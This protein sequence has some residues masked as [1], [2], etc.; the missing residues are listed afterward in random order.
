M[1][2]SDAPIDE[3][4]RVRHLISGEVGHD[5]H[6]LKAEFTKLQERF[7]RPAIEI[8]GAS[9]GESVSKPVAKAK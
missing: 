9:S 3:V 2:K 8:T 7:E 5:L 1:P 6:K 4:R